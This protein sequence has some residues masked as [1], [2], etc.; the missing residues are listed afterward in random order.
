MQ[1]HLLIR[2]VSDIRG[3]NHFEFH[4]TACVT[5]MRLSIPSN[6]TAMRDL[7][8]LSNARS[9]MSFLGSGRLFEVDPENASGKLPSSLK[10]ELE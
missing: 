10:N 5:V 8:N 2:F 7:K 1:N 3:E 6:V 9:V 4:A